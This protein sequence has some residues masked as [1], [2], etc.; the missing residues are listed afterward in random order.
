[1]LNSSPVFSF[2]PQVKENWTNKWTLATY[3]RNMGMRMLMT[4]SR[5]VIYSK[6][7]V[8]WILEMPCCKQCSL[9]L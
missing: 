2:F 5:V 9:V 3:G 6:W 4:E 1:M 7:T 8:I